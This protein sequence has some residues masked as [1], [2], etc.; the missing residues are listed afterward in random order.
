MRI[1]SEK[2]GKG[3][4]GKDRI[5]PTYSPK[6]ATSHESAGVKQAVGGNR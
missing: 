6:Q 5:R 3:N 4:G 1:T 2:R